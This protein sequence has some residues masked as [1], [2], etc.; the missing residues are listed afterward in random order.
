MICWIFR[1]RFVQDD[2]NLF[3]FGSGF[4][5]FRFWVSLSEVA[6]DG[7]LEMQGSLEIEVDI[8]EMEIEA[9]RWRNPS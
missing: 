5:G 9:L 8:L 3:D 2:D 6:G 7:S 4:V 1:D